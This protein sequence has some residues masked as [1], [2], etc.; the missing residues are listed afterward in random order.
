MLCST[1]GAAVWNPWALAC[2]FD[3][4]ATPACTL[5][6]TQHHLRNFPVVAKSLA[7][8]CF[9][10]TF[11]GNLEVYF[12]LNT[13]LLPWELEYLV[14]SGWC[15]FGRF[16][17]GP[18]GGCKSAEVKVEVYSFDSVLPKPAFCSSEMRA[19]HPTW[20]PQM[21]VHLTA[22]FLPQRL[23]ISP[24]L[25]APINPLSSRFCHVFGHKNKE[26]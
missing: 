24:K 10:R 20:P 16:V 13:K 9:F 25:W 21:G 15:C 14:P 22:M 3:W 26:K 12:G 8:T 5:W 7:E 4:T 19:G 11:F 18:P 6:K 23:T 2:C 1:V 17:M